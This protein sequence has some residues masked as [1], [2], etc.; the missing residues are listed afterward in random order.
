LKEKV[1]SKV[2]ELRLVEKRGILVVVKEVAGNKITGEDMSGKVRLIDVDELTKFSSPSAKAGFGI[3]DITSNTKISVIGLY[4]KQSKRILARFI[5]VESEPAFISG[6]VKEVDKA[7][8][9][10]KVVSEDENV[11]AID[12]ENVTKTSTYTETDDI[13]RAGF[14]K[15]QVGQRVY[16]V[17]Y[18]VKGQKQRILAS[19]FLIFPDLPANPK[20]KTSVTEP[21]EAV[22]T[23]TIKAG[24]TKTP[25]R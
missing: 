2:A 7:N 18:P 21:T 1:A 25:I 6:I 11:Y 5:T 22:P 17:G 16:I 8:F 9:I 23:P 24:S 4:N 12:I 19:R 13:K 20:I 10:V 15:I 14:S 3:S